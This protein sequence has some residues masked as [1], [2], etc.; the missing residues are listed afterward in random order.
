MAGFDIRTLVEFAPPVARCPRCLGLWNEDFGRLGL[1]RFS[2]PVCSS[3]FHPPAFPFLTDISSGSAV[4]TGHATYNTAAFSSVGLSPALRIDLGEEPLSHAMS[5]ARVASELRGADDDRPPL[6]SLMRLF[7]TS[8]SFI[9]V[10]TF[11]LDEFTLGL[12]ELAAQR[13]YISAAVSGLDKKM[14]KALGPTGAEAPALEVRVEG[15]RF[16]D[17]GDQNHGKLIVVDGLLAITGS[18]NLTHK[19]WRKAEVSMEIVD[20]VTDISRVVELNNR[21]FSPT[22]ARIEPKDRRPALNGWRLITPDDAEHSSHTRTDGE[23][24]GVS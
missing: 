24:D 13:V 9:H 1:E 20:V 7:L 19:A 15:H 12:L 22:W 10:T 6:Q 14:D 4:F 3:E 5:L 21:Y 2:C 17:L 18:A 11:G 8:R 16:G 23:A